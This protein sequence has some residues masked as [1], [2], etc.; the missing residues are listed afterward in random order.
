MTASALVTIWCDG[1]DCVQWCTATGVD[2][3]AAESR[4]AA[5]R[6][7]WAVG[8]PGGRDLCPDCRRNRTSGA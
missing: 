6:V 2:R 8:L 4:R 3:T 5:K 1:D 7:G